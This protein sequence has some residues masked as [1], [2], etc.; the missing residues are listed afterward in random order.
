VDRVASC[1]TVRR[2]RAHLR[3][4]RAHR[5]ADHGH[6]L[7]DHGHQLVLHAPQRAR[8][9]AVQALATRRA[10]TDFHVTA[11]ATVELRERVRHAARARAHHAVRERVRHEA[12]RPPDA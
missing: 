12:R 7:T 1:R 5:Q 2:A 8:D 10:V 6:Q 9:E 4:E 11:V 3:A